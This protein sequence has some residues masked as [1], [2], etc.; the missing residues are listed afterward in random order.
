MFIEERVYNSYTTGETPVESSAS[1]NL[2]KYVNVAGIEKRAVEGG[3]R[4]FRIET[5]GQEVYTASLLFF[6]SS[7]DPFDV[8][9]VGFNH[10]GYFLKKTA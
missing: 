9:L 1:M 4:N 3:T 2:E 8:E 5:I 10:E 6:N 7:R